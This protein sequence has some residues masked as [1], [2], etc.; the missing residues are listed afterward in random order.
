MDEFI[1]T[2]DD[3]IRWLSV[4]FGLLWT[5]KA[6]KPASTVVPMVS[7]KAIQ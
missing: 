3:V 4:S 5:P 6:A 7:T 1:P 2:D